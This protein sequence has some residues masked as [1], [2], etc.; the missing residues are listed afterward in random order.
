MKKILTAILFLI[1]LICLSQTD[2]LILQKN[3]RNIKTYAPGQP[4]MIHTVYDQW[5]DGTLTDLK[6]D[7]VYINDIPFHV[8]EIDAMRKDFSKLHLQGSG[9]I[10]IIAGVGVLALNV[11]N[12]LYTNEPAG[13][14]IKATGW[15]TA[16]AFIIAGFLMK[17]ARYKNYTIG[18]IY[19]LHYLN[20]RPHNV[21]AGYPLNTTEPAKQS[22]A[23]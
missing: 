17:S 20:L 11:I 7:S 9:T 13:S 5:L 15:I 4:I 8:N 10:L 1:P 19:T 21:P 3:G 23:H 2:V 18:K 16:G 14:W 12:G 22:D 6:N